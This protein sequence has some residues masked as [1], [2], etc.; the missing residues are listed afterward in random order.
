MGFPRGKMLVLG[1][2]R[3]RHLG[4]AIVDHRA[5]LKVSIDDLRLKIQR[6]ICE[7]PVLEIKIG[8]NR[9]APECVVVGGQLG[10]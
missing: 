9:A 2:A 4:I 8:V 7:S 10:S 1:D 6:A 5:A 3:V